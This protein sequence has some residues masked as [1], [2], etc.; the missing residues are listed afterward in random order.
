MIHSHALRTMAGLNPT[1]PQPLLAACHSARMWP[2]SNMGQAVRQDLIAHCV[3]R[4]KI[5]VSVE[6][7]V[8]IYRAFVLHWV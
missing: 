4:V 7:L 5:A 8:H 1:A 2:E 6:A 3:R